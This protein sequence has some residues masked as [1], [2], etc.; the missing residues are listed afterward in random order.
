MAGTSPAMT[1]V[2]SARVGTA[3]SLFRLHRRGIHADA[4]QL[5]EQR[6][7]LRPIRLGQRRLEQRSDVRAQMRGVAGAEQY[8]I[9][10]RLV[11]RKAIR[12]FGDVGRAAVVNEKAERLGEL[13]DRLVDL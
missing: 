7:K 9:H 4:G 8:H 10:T 3:L 11:T 12:G 5:P 6:R 2:N 1:T 13:C